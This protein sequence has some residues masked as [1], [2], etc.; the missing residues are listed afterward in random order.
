MSLGSAMALIGAITGCSS[1]GGSAIRTGPVHLPAY[2]GPVAIYALGEAPASA[3]ELGV[4]EVHGAQEDATVDQLLP[5]FLGKVAQIGGDIAVIEGVRARF[6][7][8]GRSH[9]ERFYYT[10]GFGAT[11]SGTRVY[12][13][14]DETMVLSMFGRA[15]ATRA[16]GMAGPP[17]LPPDA[18]SSA[19]APSPSAPAP[20]PSPSAPSPSAPAPAQTE[21]RPDDEVAP[22]SE[23]APAAEPADGAG[24]GRAPSEP[25][26]GP[27]PPAGAEERG[28]EP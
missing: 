6:G 1:V 2:A 20:A 4:V 17:L 25:S 26:L 27:D 19:P 14:T 23:A 11:C 12:N 10:C 7:L 9:V 13:T 24:A 8:D 18:P 22:P 3:V 16:P 5:K 28:G 15:M 21:A